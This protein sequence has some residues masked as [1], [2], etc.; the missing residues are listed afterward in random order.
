MVCA[1]SN[2][3]NEKLEALLIDSIIF[4]R[5]IIDVKLESGM[6]AS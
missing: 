5:V 6:E 2:S 3:I 4:D 1:A